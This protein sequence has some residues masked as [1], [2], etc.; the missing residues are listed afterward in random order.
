MPPYVRRVFL[1]LSVLAAGCGLDLKGAAEGEA[2]SGSEGTVGMSVGA[3]LTVASTGESSEGGDAVGDSSG[4]PLPVTTSDAG[5]DTGSSGSSAVDGATTLDSESTGVE[6]PVCDRALMVTGDT[7][8]AANG[9]TPLYE[10]LIALGFTVTVVDKVASSP[11]D[12]ADNCVVILSEIGSSGD[13]NT[14]FRE[15]AVGVVVLETGLYD[16]MALVATDADLWWG[17]GYDDITIV[18]PL[19]SLSAGLADVV[20]IYRGGGRGSWGVA[21][22]NAEVVAVWPGDAGLATLFG[23]E[24]GVEMTQGFV[25]P[26][27]RVAFPGGVAAVPMTKA[28]IDL[29]EAAVQWAAGD[30]P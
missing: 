11:D 7:N 2:G 9:D 12:V 1:S 26:A 25:A 5:E 19:H 28:R 14:K 24:T 20:A 18:D 13:V 15:A 30:R 10:R 16:D 27:R 29:F 23:Y 17:D 3:S 22:V 4:S 8:V 6:Q 21:G